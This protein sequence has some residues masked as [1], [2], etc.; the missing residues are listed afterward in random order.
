MIVTANGVFPLKL[1]L[2]YLDHGNIP[3]PQSTVSNFGR[4]QAL[5]D[6]R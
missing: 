4:Q 6:H 1:L 5:E 3:Q 2:H